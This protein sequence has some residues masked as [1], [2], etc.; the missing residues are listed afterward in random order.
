M[1]RF[2]RTT[3]P[4]MVGLPHQW[5]R[6]KEIA[7]TS[8]K[9]TLNRHWTTVALGAALLPLALPSAAWSDSARA[10]FQE[11]QRLLRAQQDRQAIAA[12]DRAIQLDP[13]YAEAYNQRGVAYRWSGDFRRA[14]QDHCMALACK[15]TRAGYLERG[16]TMMQY[17]SR[18]DSAGPLLPAIR[19]FTKAIQIDP[20][21]PSAYCMRG[22]CRLQMLQYGPARTDLDR[23]IALKPN[24][25]YAYGY[26]GILKIE[27]FQDRAGWA[28]LRK[29]FALN[30]RLRPWLTQQ[31]GEA[32]KLRRLLIEIRQATVR[33]QTQGWSGGSTGSWEHQCP[34][35]GNWSFSS[36]R[37]EHCNK[38][39]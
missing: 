2:A 7:M 20:R 23:A 21:E 24:Y 19:D 12:F 30:P 22:F 6:G 16:V 32:V 8:T 28:D 29:C 1:E 18:I 4:L 3:D 14:Y 26:R 13:R 31:A 10:A 33:Q 11:G 36:L 15:R 37:C 38:L 17:G 34:G 35:C 25:A 9:R 39:Q 27:R 5:V